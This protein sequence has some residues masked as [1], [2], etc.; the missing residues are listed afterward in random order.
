MLLI[1]YTILGIGK[2]EV[3][4]FTLLHLLQQRLEPMVDLDPNML[5]N[6]PLPTSTP[7]VH[8]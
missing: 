5:G 3:A 6:L 8:L 7:F 1:G 4:G 2:L